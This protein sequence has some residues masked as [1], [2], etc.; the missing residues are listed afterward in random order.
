V[1]GSR[2]V[3]EGQWN[4]QRLS[5][6]GRIYQSKRNLKVAGARPTLPIHGSTIRGA[7]CLLIFHFSHIRISSTHHLSHTL[8]VRKSNPSIGRP[9]FRLSHTGSK[10]PHFCSTCACAGQAPPLQDRSTLS[11]FAN[12]QDSCL[13]SAS[14]GLN[15]VSHHKT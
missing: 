7:S 2:G 10:L 9:R 12:L 15:L 6:K 4:I 8:M 14:L 13:V 5:D 1:V 11:S 3:A